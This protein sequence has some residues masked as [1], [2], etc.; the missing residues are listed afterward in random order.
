M[1]SLGLALVVFSALGCG[2]GGDAAPDLETYFAAAPYGVESCDHVDDALRGRREIRLYSNGAVNLAAATRALQ[3]YYDRHGLSFFATVRPEVI[4]QLFAIDTNDARLSAALAREFPGVDLSDEQAVMQDP[5]LYQRVVGFALNTMFKPMLSFAAVHGQEGSDV[6]NVVVLPQL[7]S[8]G[9]SGDPLPDDES[10]A[11]IS[12]SRPLLSA[13]DPNDPSTAP[14][15][16]LDLPPQFTPM[17]FLDGGVLAQAARRDPVLVDLVA[18]HEFG[19]T[20]GLVHRDELHNLMLP[21]VTPGQSRCSDGLD[22]DQLATMHATLFDSTPAPTPTP[23]ATAPLTAAGSR[24][25]FPPGLLS[26][27][28]GGDRKR[29]RTLLGP[30]VD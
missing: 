26:T 12:I 6:T 20:A 5:A 18:A 7:L 2:G 3:R 28:L 24:R 8:P 27:L 23:P 30:L 25:S 17:M 22:A 15:R 21:G 29:L 11:G 16:E 1:K 4:P 19:H 10:L 14:W 9:G 13:F